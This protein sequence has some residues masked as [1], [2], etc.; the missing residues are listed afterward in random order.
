MTEPYISVKVL[1]FYMWDKG[2]YGLNWTAI[3]LNQDKN[4]S[5]NKTLQVP[6]EIKPLAGLKTPCKCITLLSIN[7][8]TNYFEVSK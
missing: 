8:A 1:I 7:N 4:T 2:D 5:I 3:L 6:K